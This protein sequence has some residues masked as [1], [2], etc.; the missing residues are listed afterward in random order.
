M[1]V[2]LDI[3]DQLLCDARQLAVREGTTLRVLIERGLRRVVA[4]ANQK[5]PFQL[6]KASFKGRG[7]GLKSRMPDGIGYAQPHTEMGPD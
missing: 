1:K 4:E 5:R 7:C 6:R 3:S 2:R